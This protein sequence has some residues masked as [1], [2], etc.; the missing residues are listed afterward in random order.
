A[1]WS[2]GYHRF[3]LDTLDSYQ[4]GTQDAK[5]RE[6]QRRALCEIISAMVTRHPDVRILLN[7][8]F[9]LLPDIGKKVHGV[10]AES[11]FDRW[12]AAK[13]AYVRVPKNDYE[14]LLAR[15]REVKERYHLPVIVIDYRP[16]EE[17]AEARETAKKIAALGF[18]PWVC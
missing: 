2:K 17:R 12:D 5:K 18:Q 10:V 16:P 9:E 11:L 3:F 1:L 15:L 7:R 13:S 4:L 6:V 8:G 14:W